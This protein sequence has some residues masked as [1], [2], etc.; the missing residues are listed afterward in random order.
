VIELKEY[1]TSFDMLDKISVRDLMRWN[2][3]LGSTVLRE[4][5][6]RILKLWDTAVQMG[7]IAA[8]KS[9]LMPDYKTPL[10]DIYDPKVANLIMD[11]T[12]TITKHIH[13]MQA[14]EKN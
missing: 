11:V 12:M 10:E 6:T 8:W 7:F 13:D 9:E 14:L 5:G 3:I 2:S 1:E 4:D